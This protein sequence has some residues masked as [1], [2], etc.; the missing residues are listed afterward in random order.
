MEEDDDG[1][2]L[3]LI[4]RGFFDYLFYMVGEGKKPPGLTLAFDFR[5]T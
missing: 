4:Y 2:I 1:T 3:T 5:Q